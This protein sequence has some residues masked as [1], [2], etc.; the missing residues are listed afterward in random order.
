MKEILGNHLMHFMIAMSDHKEYERHQRTYKGEKYEVWEVSDD[1]FKDM[2]DMT[3]EMFIDLAGEDAW[4]RSSIGSNLSFLL[5]GEVKINGQIMQGWI[6]K[7]WDDYTI[8]KDE[9][10]GAISYETL[11]EY[12]CEVI[13]ASQPRNVVACAMDLAKYNNMTMGELFEKYEG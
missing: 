5:I 11:S 7:P 3:E 13:G 4:W 12:L 10:M 2:C 6:M 8:Y 1:L 9:G